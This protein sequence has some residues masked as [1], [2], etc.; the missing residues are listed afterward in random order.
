MASTRNKAGI[1][2]T[3]GWIAQPRDFSFVAILINFGDCSATW[4]FHVDSFQ[5]VQRRNSLRVL[6]ILEFG[7]ND[8]III[9]I[10]F[11]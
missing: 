1:G 6:G 7:Y 9:I 5:R 10:D 2:A 3:S 8:H 11:M 4:D